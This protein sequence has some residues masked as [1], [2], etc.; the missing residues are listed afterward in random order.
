MASAYFTATGRAASQQSL[1]DALLVLDGQA[2]ELDPEAL[3]LRVAEHE[4]DLYLDLGDAT[5]RAVRITRSGWTLTDR[6]P[7]WFR[8]TALTGAL[9]VPMSGGGLD[10]LWRLLNVAES[11][12]PLVVAW[13]V[14]A[15]HPA[16]PHPIVA[17]VGE[18]GVGK[19]GC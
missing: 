10:D 2:R 4:D 16:I 17:L 6:P 9:P 1:A 11:D 5:G 14:A 8:R 15:L 13:L 7:V 19:S 18:Q 12:R 3:W